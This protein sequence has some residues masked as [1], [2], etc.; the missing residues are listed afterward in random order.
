VNKKII[1][2]RYKPEVGQSDSERTES[3]FDIDFCLKC[4]MTVAAISLISLASIF[5][6]DF[7]TQS[8]VFNV[9]KIEIIGTGRAAQNDIL[10]LA[11][12]KTG[13]NIFEPNLFSIE[14]KISDHPWIHSVS[15]KRNLPSNIVI[16]I[17]E[18]EP[19]AIVKIENL[20]D[21]LINTK[22]QPFKEY[23]PK[24]DQIKGLPVI[25]GLD[26]TS[27]NN[28][29]QFHG[30]LFNS[31]MDLLDIQTMSQAIEIKGDKNTGLTI[32]TIDIYNKKE[33]IEQDTLEIKLG[34]N[35]FQAKLYRAKEISNYIDKYL[36]DRVII[37]MDL[38]NVEKV[39]IK[40]KSYDA[41]H[42]TLEKGV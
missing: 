16:S 32:Q 31:T 19:L 33:D 30:P 5:F 25:S 26:L 21:I 28:Q 8:A 23:N 13:K 34:F 24:T 27:K 4:I 2:N 17:V 15:V 3:K 12:L 37:A 39:F 42:N 22:G 18:Q 35:D 29:Y 38:F 6:Y 7:I 41:L 9:K 20:A 11:D 10:K 40:T 36:P 14:K 1:Q